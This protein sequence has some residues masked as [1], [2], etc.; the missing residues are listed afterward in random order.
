M[1]YFLSLLTSLSLAGTLAGVTLPESVTIK[2]QKLLLNGMGL[3]E[4]Y[5]VDV[6]VAGLY[7]AKRSKDAKH[8]IAAEVP[9][10][11]HTQFIYH[12]ITKKQMQETLK[13]NL[14]KNPSIAASVHTQMQRCSSWMQDF[15]AGDSIIFDYHPQRGTTV[16]INGTTKGT[17]QGSAFMQALFSIYIGDHPASQQ[18][19]K[20]LLNL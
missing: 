16:I 12:K 10:R 11:I 2:N 20:G 9:K 5:W 19:K 6:Y 1:I 15:T 3:R 7:M 14:A 18:L 17:I 4:K 13:E 8:I